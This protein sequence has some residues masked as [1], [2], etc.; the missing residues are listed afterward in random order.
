MLNTNQVSAFTGLS[1]QQYALNRGTSTEGRCAFISPSTSARTNTPQV[2]PRLT[3]LRD[4]ISFQTPRSSTQLNFS[5]EQLDAGSVLVRDVFLA[6][7]ASTGAMFASDVLDRFVD[8]M[9]DNEQTADQNTT[10]NGT[11]AENEQKTDD[12]KDQGFLNKSMQKKIIRGL[13]EG[14]AILTVMSSINLVMNDVAIVKTA[15]DPFAGIDNS[16]TRVTPN[17][18]SDFTQA[19]EVRS[20]IDG[21]DLL[22]KSTDTF[23]S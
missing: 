8:G 19:N 13:G 1:T 21:R 12:K 2:T 5:P 9:P 7:L 6:G 15:G 18:R 4:Q 17:M 23:S 10:P 3:S 16:I 11:A 14:A 22:S 20:P